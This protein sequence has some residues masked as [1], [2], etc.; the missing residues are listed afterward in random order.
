MEAIEVEA[1]RKLKE[2]QE[3]VE[4][5]LKAAHEAEATASRKAAA[6]EAQ[7]A[8]RDAAPSQGQVP[9]AST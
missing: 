1:A 4:Q 5:K 3:V 9:I 7:L 2:A 8:T 6:L